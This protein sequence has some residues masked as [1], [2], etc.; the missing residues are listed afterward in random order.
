MHPIRKKLS[1]NPVLKALSS[2]KIMV[3][4]LGLLFILTLWGTIDQVYNGLYLAQ[5]RFFNSWAFTFWGFIPFPGARLVLWVMFINLVC[6]ALVRLVYRWSKLGITV[7]HSGLLLFFLAAFVTFHCVEESNITLM[8][9]E[10]TNVAQAY[11]NWELSVWEQEGNKKKV[12]AFD[13]DRLRKGQVLAYA[14]FGLTAVV[15]SYYRNCEAYTKPMENQRE[16]F[17]NASGISSF[18]PVPL[19]VEP[20]KNIPGIVFELKGADGGDVYV[21][22]YGGER[23]PLA[24]TRGGKTYYMELRLKRFPIPFI[25]RLKEFKM[26][27]HPNT[28]IAR[29]YESLVEIISGGAAREVL[30]SMNEPLRHNSYTMY[31]SSYSIDPLGREHSTL[32]VVKNQGR[33]LPYIATFVVSAG[34]AIHLLLMAFSVPSRLPRKKKGE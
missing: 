32:A 1:K 7:I 34:L 23:K 19:D 17:L 12:A 20:Q 33:V 11:H 8:E 4:C 13:T 29:S 6:V 25:V 27:R 31:Q 22:L 15:D 21:L 28:E 26:E 30:I 18:H 5:A 10:G 2:V 3:V 14:T 16:T 24:V 9:G